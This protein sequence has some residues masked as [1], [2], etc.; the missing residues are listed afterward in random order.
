MNRLFSL[1]TSPFRR[2]G[3][4]VG[5]V[6]KTLPAKTTRL[7]LD[8]LDD[9]CLP[10]SSPLT[11]SS[12]HNLYDGSTLVLSN[13]EQYIWSSATNMGYALQQGG[14]L[15]SFTSSSPTHVHAVLVPNAQSIGVASDGTVYALLT[16]GQLQVSTNSGKSW[17]AIDTATES[18]GVASNGGLFEL[19]DGGSLQFSANRGSTWT[20]ID[21]DTQSFFV[22]SND[23]LYNLAGAGVLESSIDSGN[24][25]NTLDSQTES[26]AVTTAGTLYG[27]DGTGQLWVLPVG[28]SRKVLD[29]TTQAFAVTPGGTLYNLYTG[30]TLKSST[31]SGSSWTTLDSNTQTFGVSSNSALYVL[32]TGGTLRLQSTSGGTWQTLDTA[33]QSFSLT[34]DGIVFDLDTD[35]V[36][37]DLPLLSGAWP[38]YDTVAQAIAVTPNGTL[39]VMDP[40]GV[41]WDLDPAGY[42][43]WLENNVQSFSVTTGGMLYT[44]QQGG[45]LQSAAGPNGAWNA[46]DYA[47]MSFAVSPNGTLYDLDPGSQLWDLPLGGSWQWLDGGTQS[48]SLTPN[49]TLVDLDTGGYLWALPYD[50]SWEVLNNNTQSYTINGNGTIYNLDQGFLEAAANT[51]GLWTVLNES[52]QAFDVTPNGVIEDLTGTTPEVSLNSGKSWLNLFTTEVPDSGLASLAQSDFTRDDALTRADMIGLFGEAEADGT[53]TTAEYAS[54]EVLVDSVAVTMPDDVR[55]LAGKVVNGNLADNTFQGQPLGDLG[56]GSSSDQLNDLVQK[57]FYGADLPATD[58]NPTTGANFAYA[59]AGGTLFGASGVPSY[60]D[61]AQGYAADCYFLASLGQL[62]LQSPQEVESM[63]TNNGDGTYTVRF[64]ENGVPDYVTVNSDLPVTSSGTFAYAGYYQYGQ[65]TTVSSGSNVLWVALA[66]KAYAQ[67]AEEGWSRA[68][69]GAYDNSYDSINYGWPTTVQSQLTGAFAYSSVILAG[70]YATSDAESVVVNDI[71][72]GNLI[73]IL[74]LATLPDDQSPF[75]ANHA[76]TLEGYDPTTGLFTFVNPLDDGGGDGPRV[77]QVTWDQLAPYVFDFEDVMP[78]AGMSVSSVVGNPYP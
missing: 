57:W 19:D 3:S 69:H 26:F 34:S 52:T 15:D 1:L 60:N 51:N 78:P 66:E 24:T 6:R 32:D 12:N 35:G 38:E 31:N 47:T 76:Y 58:I 8:A 70:S 33:T 74:T 77:V 22:T 45:L 61:V 28:G 27:L 43:Q 13:V 72:Q 46:L 17:T 49:G 53:V 54:L 75:I 62:A 50:G 11:W 39:Y 2:A 4:G 71:T 29:S 48:F 30:G 65:P 21:Q 56:P 67:L 59:P 36:I 37:Q 25:W 41:L 44:L 10:S 18:F 7:S 20:A 42:W 9:R 64:Y 5:S 63:F 68:D 55:N 14:T 40:G 16:G 23:T 73:S